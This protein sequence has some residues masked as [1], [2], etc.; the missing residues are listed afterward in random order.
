[1]AWQTAVIKYRE[2][3]GSLSASPLRLEIG[4]STISLTSFVDAFE[5]QV[6]LDQKEPKLLVNLELGI[7]LTVTGVF[8]EFED[9]G[10]LE[11]FKIN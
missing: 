1:M 10:E 2:E 7:L 11:K 6:Y 9:F 4:S 5:A 3:D 8:D